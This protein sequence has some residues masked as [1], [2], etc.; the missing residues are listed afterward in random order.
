MRRAFESEPLLVAALFF[1]SGASGLVFEVLWVRS[2][3]LWVGQTTVAVSLVVAAFLAGLVAGSSAGGRLADSSARPLRLYGALELAVGATALAVTLLLSRLSSGVAPAWAAGRA[4]RVAVAF[5]VVLPPTCAMGATLPVLTRHLTR[6]V[7]H[8]GRSFGALYAVNTLGAACGCGLAG[9]VLLGAFGVRRTAL[10]A[11]AVN[12]AVGVVALAWERRR[13]VALGAVAQARAARVPGGAG[14]GR[15]HAIA[16]ATG[17]AAIACE[18]LWF[19]VLRA[20]IESSTYAFTLLL[21]TFLCALVAGGALYARV[22]ARRADPRALLSD[23]QVL[24]AFAGLASIGALGA[25]GKVLAAVS[26]GGARWELAHVVVAALVIFVPASLMGVTYP[27]VAQLAA[28]DPER[29]GRTVGG[30]AAANTIGGVV[31]SLAFGLWLIPLLGAQL[32]LLVAFAV[33]V[34]VAAAF[35]AGVRRRIA[36]P[37]LFALGALL[38]P[39]RYVLDAI[40]TNARAETLAAVEG[41]DGTL[42]VQGFTRASVCRAWSDCA[43]HCREDFA[44]QTLKFGSMSYASTLPSPRRYMRAQAHLAMLMRPRAERVLLVCFGTGTTAAAFAAH[45]SVRS[46]TIVDVNPDVFAAAPHFRESNADVLADPRVRRVVEDGR[47]F[48]ATTKEEFDVVSFEP[49]PP[50]AEGAASLYSSEF[51]ALARRRL[52]PG[53]VLTQW[54]PLAQQDERV[55]RALLRSL[56]D[57]WPEVQLYVPS[58]LEGVVLASSA[59]MTADLAAWRARAAASPRLFENADEVSLAA[60]E[61]LL[62]SLV[63]DPAGTRRLVGDAPPVTDDLPIVEFFRSSGGA[64]FSIDAVLRLASDPAAVAPAATSEERARI[65]REAEGAR[66]QMRAKQAALAGDLEGARS[67]A[68]RARDLLGERDRYARHLTE[69]E[70][71]CLSPG[72]RPL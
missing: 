22:L 42:Y 17:F 1:C 6:D 57:T 48:L 62:G 61:Q 26:S 66:L 33:N 45:P 34:A 19:R 47:H 9:F 25:A 68:R 39:R 71:D 27:L 72:D 69:L 59:P 40:T 55:D 60:G 54:I 28:R 44:F 3:G 37:A 41:R 64:P 51:Y 31:A 50:I 46:L 8:L 32:G 5:L 13:F 24:L 53:G 10:A 58:W 70:L 49:P 4:V 35:G 23:A 29:V 7:A 2:L 52:A 56:L 18:V 30:L 21:V 38:L 16:F 63:L 65:A 15:Y 20:F 12:V 36:A 43:A 14:L 11:V 67:L